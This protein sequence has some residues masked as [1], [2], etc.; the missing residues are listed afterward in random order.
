MAKTWIDP[1]PGYAQDASDLGNGQEARDA[2]RRMLVRFLKDVMLQSDGFDGI[3]QDSLRVAWRVIAVLRQRVG[4]F[5]VC[6]TLM[7]EFQ[8]GSFHLGGRGTIRPK[9]PPGLMLKVMSCSTV[10]MP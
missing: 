4:D 3:G 5:F 7:T 2:A 1:I 9:R 6:F 10:W 8:D